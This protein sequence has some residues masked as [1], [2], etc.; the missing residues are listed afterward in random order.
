[1]VASW[2]DDL[3]VGVPFMDAEHAGLI[4]TLTELGELVNG[5][6]S[7]DTNPLAQLPRSTAVRIQ[8]S[9][10]RVEIGIHFS[11]EEQVMRSCGYPLIVRHTTKH[12]KFMDELDRMTSRFTTGEEDIAERVVR[13]VQVWFARHTRDCDTQLS[14][15]LLANHPTVT[16]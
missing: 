12:T 8:L 1:M 16:I 2:K 14:A 3:T 13:F 9:R 11:H 15:W 10:L 6:S 7:E 5:T 4:S